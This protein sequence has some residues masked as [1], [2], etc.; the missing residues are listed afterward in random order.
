[1]VKNIEIIR[2]NIV[3][4]ENETD[5]IK[6]YEKPF[7]ETERAPFY[8]WH[9]HGTLYPW[10]RVVRLKSRTTVDGAILSDADS[11]PDDIL[12]MQEEDDDLIK[13]TSPQE[14]RHYFINDKL[15]PLKEM[16]LLE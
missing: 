5:F 3:E 13:I 15:Q 1:M 7:L 12:A 2:E 16:W 10:E 9:E 8:L 4:V 6:Y 11:T 14:S